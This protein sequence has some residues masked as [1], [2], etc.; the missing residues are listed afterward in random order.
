MTP[1]EILSKV[2][3][4]HEFIH[5]SL[6]TKL[7]R[8]VINFDEIPISVRGTM[9]A[10]KTVAV[11]GD[12]DVVVKVNPN[13]SKRCATLISGAV[14]EIDENFNSVAHFF[15]KPMILWKAKGVIMQ[16]E[17]FDPRTGRAFTPKGVAN[18]EFFLSAYVPYL[19][20]QLFEETAHPSL[21]ISDS[22]RSY[23]TQQVL[24]S[25]LKSAHCYPAVFPAGCTSWIQ[26]IDVYYASHY[27]QHE[28]LWQSEHNL[29][30]TSAQ[31]RQW[32]HSIVA[33][34]HAKT[35]EN[36][37]VKKQFEH[38][39]YTNPTLAKLRSKTLKNY[40][41]VPSSIEPENVATTTENI[42][43]SFKKSLQAATGSSLS[44][45][46]LDNWGFVL[47]KKKPDEPIHA[48]EASS[49]D[50]TFPESWWTFDQ[51]SN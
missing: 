29:P 23:V 50:K 12:P 42:E 28:K 32:V 13:D 18:T 38:L 8:R 44:R 43:E 2:Q 30:R 20:K 37:D 39:G 24:D 40:S 25:F 9:S 21:L 4:F 51:E 33:R 41:F 49:D 46:R 7:F 3:K 27:N 26:W 1:D 6:Q 47:G 22:C 11:R 10:L 31:K 17:S 45:S 34:A 35:V 15:L 14:V 5:R 48:P 36:M 16:K 19:K